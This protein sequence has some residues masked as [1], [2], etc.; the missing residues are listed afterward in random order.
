MVKS[1]KDGSWS[2]KRVDIILSASPLLGD[3]EV[4][5]MVVGGR[6][7]NGNHLLPVSHLSFGRT[8]PHLF[9]CN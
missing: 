9:V 3:I 7:E 2:Q 1:F 6:I 8:T 4:S 5:R